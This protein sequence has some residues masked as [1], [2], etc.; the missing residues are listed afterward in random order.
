[1]QYCKKCGIEICGNKQCCPLCKGE[2][3]GTPER[4]V[5]P[6]IQR[7]GMS[8]SNVWKLAVF[9]CVA[10]EVILGCLLLLWPM[11]WIPLAML[12]GFLTLIGGLLILYYR[13]NAIK[14]A[15]YG[16]YAFM[17]I[18][19]IFAYATGRFGYFTAWVMPVCFT[20]LIPASLLINRISHLY[21]EDHM[22]YLAYDIVLSFIQIIF[23]LNGQNPFPAPAVLSMGFMVIFGAAL[24]IFRSHELKRAGSKYFH[25]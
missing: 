5:F 4:D 21:L 24:I 9:I 14:V 1:M 19:C 20:A 16:T 22:I 18:A 6:V 13:H 12:M 17:G 23:V 10:Y 15:T 3:T 8:R 7:H 2:L 25:I 11:H